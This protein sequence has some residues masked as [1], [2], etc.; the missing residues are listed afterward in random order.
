M[1]SPPVFLIML[2]VICFLDGLEL[3][4]CPRGATAVKIARRLRRVN[5]HRAAI[6]TL[7]LAF[8]AYMIVV[9]TASWISERLQ[10]PKS[11]RVLEEM[12]LAEQIRLRSMEAVTAFWFFALGATIG[13]F[14][15]VVAYRMPRGQS[16]IFR[17]SRCPACGT[18]INSRDNLPILGWLL[19]NGRCRECQ[20]AISARY[21]IVESLAAALFLLLFFVQLI[22]GGANI[23]VREPNLYHGV[24]WIIFY[25]KWDLVGLYL[26]HCFLLSV[27]LA[28]TLIDTDRQR[29][30]AR[31]K[32]FVG[33][34]LFLPLLIWPDL[35]PLLLHRD[36]GRWMDQSW[37]A[38]GLSSLLG[39]IVG[40]VLGRLVQWA[41][42]LPQR[43]PAGGVGLAAPVTHATS[44]L[45]FIGMAL[46]WQAAVMVGLITL[47]IGL[48]MMQLVHWRRWPQPTL[49]AYL[50]A[51][52]VLHHIMWR[53]TVENRVLW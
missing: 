39:G 24:V 7:V 1:F 32:W 13:S 30:P 44:G 29:V 53:W 21:P 25:T 15:N 20:A 33:G 9:P 38:A 42:Y 22:S 52:F 35:L 18:Q 12:S 8:V 28:W 23:P 40:A 27:L 16:V 41:A 49:T 46:G 19:L 37:L 26:Y 31:A 17:R 4:L 50:M 11:G 3:V 6:W 47:M 48:A 43:L 14:V 10:P 5:W 51:A 34:C 36:T 45:A 2:G